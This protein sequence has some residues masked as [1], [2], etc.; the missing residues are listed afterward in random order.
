MSSTCHSKILHC[1]SYKYNDKPHIYLILRL[2]QWHILEL[3]IHKHHWLKSSYWQYHKKNRLQILLRMNMWDI[4]LNNFDIDLCLSLHSKLICINTDQDHHCWDH[5]IIGWVLSRKFYSQS[6]LLMHKSGMTS[7]MI[8]RPSW[9]DHHIFWQD[10][11]ILMLLS[12]ALCNWSHK[13]DIYQSSNQHYKF[14]K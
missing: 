2:I 9:S 10:S 7:D 8:N 1:M 6:M 4:L 13:K 11:C 3:D 12:Q 5:W 14:C